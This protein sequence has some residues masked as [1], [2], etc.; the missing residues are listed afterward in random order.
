M[1]SVRRQGERSE[2]K[3]ILLCAVLEVTEWNTCSERVR[4]NGCNEVTGSTGTL[5]EN[6]DGAGKGKCID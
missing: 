6:L 3:H 5:S 2:M 4:S 1:K